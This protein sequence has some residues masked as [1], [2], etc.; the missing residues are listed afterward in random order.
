MTGAAN[1]EDEL[2]TELRALTPKVKANF[3]CRGPILT[4]K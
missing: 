3:A 2:V 4:P 1:I